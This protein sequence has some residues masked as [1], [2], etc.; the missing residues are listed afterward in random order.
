VGAPGVT[1]ANRTAFLESAIAMTDGSHGTQPAL[2]FAT[3][4]PL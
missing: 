4:T 3:W 2:P 1:A